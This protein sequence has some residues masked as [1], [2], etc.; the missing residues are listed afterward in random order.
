MISPLT[1]I[2]L[3]LAVF[4]G[5]FAALRV[6]SR[7]F[8][9]ELVRK[10]MHVGMGLVTLS[11]PWLFHAAWPVLVLAGTASILLL[12]VRVSSVMKREFGGVLHAVGRESFGEFFY[13]IGVAVLFVLSHGDPLLY[14]VPLLTL[15]FADATA[16]LIGARYASV[17]FA[18]PDGIKSLEGSIACFAVAFL[19]VHVPLLLFSPIGRL[20]SLLIALILGL[21]VMLVEAV[22]WRGLDNL[23]IPLAGFALLANFLHLDAAALGIRLGVVVLLAAFSLAMRRQTTLDDDALLAGVLFGFGI[24]ALGGCLWGLAPA[25]LVINDVRHGLRGPRREDS[26]RPHNVHAVESV[27]LAGLVW[28]VLAATYNDPDLPL[29][30]ENVV[31]FFAYLLSFAIHMAIFESTNSMHL[32]PGLGRTNALLGATLLSWLAVFGPP[33]VFLTY[34]GQGLGAAFAALVALPFIALAVQ[35]FYWVQPG[36]DD[37]P[38]DTPRWVRQGSVALTVSALGI[39]GFLA[40]AFIFGLMVL[41]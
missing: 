9:P 28:V 23:T 12:S 3:V 14:C 11:F 15:T 39:G 36:V 40:G 4:G 35:I 29:R 24:W 32:N 2:A 37:C 6:A 17:R 20:E 30:I 27:C 38:L 16:A 31:F 10:L 22:A 25:T 7:K 19:C 34:V 41:G 21:L 18:T 33:A 13:T 8:N 5:L 26:P 1:G